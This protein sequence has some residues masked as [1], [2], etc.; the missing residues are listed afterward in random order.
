MKEMDSKG[1]V[2]DTD[3]VRASGN[4]ESEHPRAK[5]CCNFLE[6]VWLLNH[7]V[8]ITV[9]IRKEW[10]K[11][12]SQFAR[13]WWVSMEMRNR[14]CP[15]NLLQDEKLRT[16]ILCTARSEK[17]IATMKKDF[18]LLNAA[19]ATDQKIISCEKQIRKL[20]ARASEK[21]SEIRHIIWVNPER[22]EE[23]QPIA[24]LKNGAPAEEY[25]QLSNFIP[26]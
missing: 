5:H 24:W 23:E 3:V 19:L 26:Y 11:Y 22:T 25:R 10:D 20:F 14:V 2:I 16:K 6:T 7:R 8:V 18:H 12:A 1:F 9:E 15:I 13:R 21:V 4:R 17:Q